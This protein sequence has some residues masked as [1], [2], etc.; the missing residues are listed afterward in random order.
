MWIERE[1]F[2]RIRLSSI[3][4]SQMGVIGVGPEMERVFTG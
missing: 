4:F 1:W 2:F 3:F